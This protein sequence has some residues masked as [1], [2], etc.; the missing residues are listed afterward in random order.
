MSMPHRK[1][2]RIPSRDDRYG[3]GVAA[4]ALPIREWAI[5]ALKRGLSHEEIAR[6]SNGILTKSSVGNIAFR[7]LRTPLGVGGK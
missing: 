6:K 2:H 5:A 4:L 3:H 1:I 7:Y